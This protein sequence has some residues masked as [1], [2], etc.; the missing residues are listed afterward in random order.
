MVLENDKWMNQ[1]HQAFTETQAS[2]IINTIWFYTV[3][4]QGLEP[5]LPCFISLTWYDINKIYLFL[6]KIIL[7][8]LA[9]VYSLSGFQTPVTS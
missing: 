2:T 5:E 9:K 4:Y 7:L 1:G 6:E 3:Y 8:F